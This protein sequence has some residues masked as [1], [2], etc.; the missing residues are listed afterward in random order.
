LLTAVKPP[1]RFTNPLT[2]STAIAPG[3]WLENV[4]PF[5]SGST[6]SR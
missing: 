1:K 2:T 3:Y 5:G 4:V 6:A